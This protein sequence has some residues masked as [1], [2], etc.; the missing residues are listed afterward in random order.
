MLHKLSLLRSVLVFLLIASTLLLSSCSDVLKFKYEGGVLLDT[1]N[2]IKYT[3]ASVSYEPVS[4]SSEYATFNGTSLYKMPNS[5]PSQ[6]LSERYNGLGAVYYA[7]GVKL[8][9]LEQFNPT[10]A[11]ICTISEKTI[12]IASIDDIDVIDELCDIMINGEDAVYRDIL[13]NYSLKLVS[14]DYPFLYYN[15]VYTLSEDGGV[16]IYDRGTKRTVEIGDLLDPYF[17]VDLNI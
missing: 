7:E 17:K 16:Y 3:K 10:K 6:W 8:P 9:T 15:V 4:I 11:I 1:K 2:N 14:E 5:D 13:D 12:G